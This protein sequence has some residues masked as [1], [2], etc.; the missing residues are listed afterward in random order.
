[1]QVVGWGK[2]ESN[3]ISKSP[4]LA[5]LPIVSQEECLRSKQDFYYLT[6]NTTLCAGARNGLGTL[7]IFN[8]LKTK[9]AQI[10]GVGPCNGDSGGG[11][12]LK[13][14]DTN[15]IDRWFLRGLVSLSLQD[16]ETQMCDLSNYIVFTDL[17]KF[18]GWIYE[19]TRLSYQ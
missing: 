5:V 11:M 16:H 7:F 6:F 4:K 9:M 19:V 13:A 10:S 2:D 15:G 1:M 8:F 18:G 14:Q 17:S 12:Y 3:K